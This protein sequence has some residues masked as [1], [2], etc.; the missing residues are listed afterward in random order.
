MAQ[1]IS[2]C[3]SEHSPE[4]YNSYIASTLNNLAILHEKL[5]RY[6]EAESEYK[7]ALETY[8]HLATTNT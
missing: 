1:W 7:E 5:N 8:R 3:F 6:K 4:L 2:H